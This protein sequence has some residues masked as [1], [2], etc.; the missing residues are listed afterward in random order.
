MSNQV[1]KLEQQLAEMQHQA[2]VLHKLDR[3]QQN[4]DFKE[5]ILKEFCTEEAAR[6][7]A[8]SVNL[9]MDAE[10][11]ASSLHFAQAC[12]L[13]RQWMAVKVQMGQS[14]LANMAAIHEAIDAARAESA[15]EAAE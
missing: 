15:D 5:L 2:E 14:A 3:L 11:R 6:Y 4:A 13:L 9:A 12:G 1:E 8:G 10:A 7:V